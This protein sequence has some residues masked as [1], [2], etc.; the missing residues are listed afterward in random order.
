[1]SATSGGGATFTLRLP[2]LAVTAREADSLSA[3]A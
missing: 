1:V 3:R 2:Q